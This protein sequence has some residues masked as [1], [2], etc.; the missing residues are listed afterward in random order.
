MYDVEQALASDAMSTFTSL[1]QHPSDKIKTLAALT[2]FHLRFE[3]ADVLCT[4]FLIS[5]DL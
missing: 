4:A 1:L 5:A 3:S 2:I